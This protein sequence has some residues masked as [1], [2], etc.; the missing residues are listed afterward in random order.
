MIC[1]SIKYAVEKNIKSD[2]RI[3][4]G[5]LEKLCST[6]LLFLCASK[7]V[8]RLLIETLKPPPVRFSNYR[9]SYQS[10]NS[11]QDPIDFNR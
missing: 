9:Q 2:F 11:L 5:S 3:T 8:I 7:I 1:K 6:I 10:S 4:G